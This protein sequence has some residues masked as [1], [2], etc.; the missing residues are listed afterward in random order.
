[1]IRTAVFGSPG[2][3]DPA[4]C[5]ET[6]DELDAFRLEH[7]DVTIWCG[8]MFEGGC[9]R[10]LTTRRCTDKICHF[11]HYGTS[12][13]SVR[14]ARTGRG[15]DSADH[16]YAKAHLAA[17]LHAQGLTAQFTYP[18][19]LGSAVLVQ[20]EDGRTLLVHL[21]RNQPADWNGDFWEIILGPGVRV[22][23][24]ILNERGY[25]QRLRFEDR[26][27]GG[28][29]MRFGTEHPSQGT[30]WDS[31]DN[32]TLT[33]KGLNTTTRPDAVR[34]PLT[35]DPRPRQPAAPTRRA[36]I[37]IAPRPNGASTARQDDAV[38]LAVMHLD[39]ALREQP[40]L[41]YTRV[42]AIKRLLEKD[43]L[44]ENVARLRLALKRGQE[45]LDQRTRERESL[46]QELQQTPTY[47]L[48]TQV[49][50]LMNDG[51]V[52]AVER[53]VHRLAREKVNAEQAARRRQQQEQN[54]AQRRQREA[55]QRA[56]REQRARAHEQEEAEQRALWEQHEVAREHEEAERRERAERAEARLRA[57][58]Q[59]AENE[60]AE[61]I[62]YLAPFVLGALKKAAR[63]ARVTTWLEIRERT[64]QRDLVRLSYEDRLSVLQAVEK[65][66]K[67]DAPLWS[68]ILAA[69]G[70]PEALHLYRDLAAHLRRP[71]PDDDTELLAHATADCARL[72]WQ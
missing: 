6:P 16:L 43:H 71:V 63:E 59:Q 9:G 66:T 68:T 15:K 49:S 72:R 51:N 3:D 41:L 44:P 2:S 52:S 24:H 60:R 17:W 54:A 32:V 31:L 42:G 1:M 14:C 57:A 23:A 46:L 27:G 11:A 5:P 48:L 37:D 25:V 53:E 12:D 56:W 7:A 26:P 33:P 62:A 20:F 39:R 29:V 28:R 22:P 13:E 40:E 55:E 4:L 10:R 45:G 35:D 18:E 58:A 50:N 67:P 8:T 19:P 38:K 47:A 64:G 36:I 65:K 30:T 34:A 21:D 69:T 61:K 70:T